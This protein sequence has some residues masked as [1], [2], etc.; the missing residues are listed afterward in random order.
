[1]LPMPWTHELPS[2]PFK[3]GM[4]GSRLTKVP[5]PKTRNEPCR[6][7]VKDSPGSSKGS[8]ESTKTKMQPM[9]PKSMSKIRAGI[10]R[11]MKRFLYGS[12]DFTENLK[13]GRLQADVFAFPHRE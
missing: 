7:L 10:T 12:L 5:V 9:P 11:L 4:N 6:L 13:R 8:S 3:H 1:M 2:I